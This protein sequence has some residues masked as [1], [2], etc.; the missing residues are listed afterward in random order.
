MIGVRI[1]HNKV[2][3][4]QNRS[5]LFEIHEI[6]H[7][8]VK[9]FYDVNNDKVLKYIWGKFSNKL[10]HE[11]KSKYIVSDEL[12]KELNEI[13]CD[14]SFYQ[15]QIFNDMLMSDYFAKVLIDKKADST[16]SPREL[17]KLNRL[18]F[19]SYFQNEISK[20]SDKVSK[21]SIYFNKILED[22]SDCLWVIPRDG[23]CLPIEWYWDNGN[24]AWEISEYEKSIIESHDDNILVDN[25]FMSIYSKYIRDDWNELVC[26]KGNRGYSK[27]ISEF[28]S[29]YRLEQ[30]M[31]KEI[32]IESVIYK[33]W[34]LKLIIYNWDS[35]F[36]EIIDCVNEYYQ[37]IEENLKVIPDVSVERIIY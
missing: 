22:L 37:N 26:F 9:R 4:S 17:Q 5:A 10:Q 27:Q 19:E 24:E 21:F 23:I 29:N 32:N 12:V 7:E 28:I 25:S 1:Y 13:I 35:V 11:L 16:I 14:P 31:E 6:K 2:L 30:I 15:S 8:F 34:D 3:E 20:S 33:E 18:V 36:W